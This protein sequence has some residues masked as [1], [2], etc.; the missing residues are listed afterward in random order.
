M[1]LIATKIKNSF[2]F[3][4]VSVI[5]TVIKI[6]NSISRVQII[7]TRRLHGKKRIAEKVLNLSGEQSF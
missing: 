3:R 2:F 1:I 6:P 5:L 4:S 7:G